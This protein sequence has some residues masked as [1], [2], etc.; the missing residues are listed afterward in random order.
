M[1]IYLNTRTFSQDYI[2]FKVDFDGLKLSNKN[3]YSIKELQKVPIDDNE[4]TI[5]LIKLNN[6]NFLLFVNNLNSH[7]LDQHERE[8]KNSYIFIYDDEKF[9]RE[10]T[11]FF[12][13]EENPLKMEF[14]NLVVEIENELIA[15]Y[16]DFKIH[17]DEFLKNNNVDINL[18]EDSSY[19]KK[20]CKF[21]GLYLVHE[22][23][24]EINYQLNT[25]IFN[26]V[27]NFLFKESFP[28][29][30]TN[31]FLFKESLTFEEILRGEF[32]VS[33]AKSLDEPATKLASL[34]IKRF[35][36][37]IIEEKSIKKLLKKFN[38]HRSNFLMILIFIATIPVVT[39]YYNTYQQ[40]K[41][42][43]KTNNNLNLQM[44]LLKKENKSFLEEITQL[45]KDLKSQSKIVQEITFENDQLKS[46][47]IDLKESQ[48]NSKCDSNLIEK[49]KSDL[50]T[51]QNRK[52][53]I[54]IQRKKLSVGYKWYKD[55]YNKCKNSK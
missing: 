18:H 52:K 55:L 4:F 38:E 7:R 41:K 30:R 20:V 32:I 34:D 16:K 29:S 6:G 26:E 13:Y 53:R 33:I 17:L 5:A 24:E 47:I 1:D 12:L 21:A 28:D 31:I 46:D 3:W 51:C 49:L 35:A 23:H 8:I 54:S 27:K 40:N 44:E 48:K 10:L 2:W 19:E 11:M 50:Q 15:N 43:Y 42:L 9:M 39:L 25:L 37:I 36:E 22:K 14:L 45:K